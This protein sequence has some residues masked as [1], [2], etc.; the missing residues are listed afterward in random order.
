MIHTITNLVGVIVCGSQQVE[1]WTTDISMSTAETPLSAQR[2]KTADKDNT[3]MF[4]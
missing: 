2:I 4:T 1:L 3:I